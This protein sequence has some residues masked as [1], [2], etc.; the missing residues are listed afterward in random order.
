MTARRP[1]GLFVGLAALDLIQRVDAL[2]CP[3][4]KVTASWQELSAGGPALNA[5]VTFAALGG[6][7]TLLTRI[8]KGPVAR[9]IADDLAGHGIRVLD[10]A[11]PGF[12]PAVSA[13][14]IDART[15]D[16]QIVSTDGG[17]P[18]PTG[19]TAP[20]VELATVLPGAAVIL[21]DGH[22]PDL[23]AATL[24]HPACPD[25]P[26]VLDAGRYKPQFKTLLPRCTDVVCSAEFAFPSTGGD[27]LAQ[28]L[29]L[30]ARVAAVS[31]GPHPIRWAAR[32]AEGPPTPETGS[33]R[34]SGTR[35]G[36]VPVP[37]VA[38]VDTL[39]AGDAL[40]GAYAWALAHGEGADP[41]AHLAFAANVASLSTTHRGTRRWLAELR[42]QA[43]P[44]GAP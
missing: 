40:H 22:H 20:P 21:F 31:A 18:A 35:T 14:T 10:A 15:A 32:S 42:G 8:G 9:L 3:N 27:L 26:V 30:G 44:R 13:I 24:D 12:T 33:T 28:L 43:H 25:V 6:D 7:A 5:A 4:T 41:P 1:A 36:T 11:A 17:T 2:P 29:R 19:Q 23:A 37:Q 34:A 16:R 39:G 38:A